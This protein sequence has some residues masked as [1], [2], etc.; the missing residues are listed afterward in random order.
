MFGYSLFSS[1]LI[2]EPTYEVSGSSTKVVPSGIMRGRG[3]V[4]GNA[5][6]Y[7]GSFVGGRGASVG[8][9]SP[10]MGGRGK[11]SASVGGPV[12]G[13]VEGKASVSM[14]GRGLNGASGGTAV[15]AGSRFRRPVKERL[16]SMEHFS[17]IKAE[18]K[19]V[20]GPIFIF[21]CYV[22][23]FR[24]LWLHHTR[25]HLYFP[26]KSHLILSRSLKNVRIARGCTGGEGPGRPEIEGWW[27]N[28]LL[29]TPWERAPAVLASRLLI[30]PREAVPGEPWRLVIH[31]SAL[32]DT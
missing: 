16:G 8:V 15:Y 13:H 30:E 5:L 3:R 12:G 29:Q 26:L 1:A 21:T 19:K 10:I 9:T 18:T 11:V 25:R 14:G 7:V 27:M 23:N 31:C 4:E 24:C 32:H 20:G 17:D 28:G 22:L 2:Q 6:A